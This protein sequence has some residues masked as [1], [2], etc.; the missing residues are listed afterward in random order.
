MP[1]HPNLLWTKGETYGGNR[2][3]DPLVKPTLSV[4][5]AVA[6]VAILWTWWGIQGED[7]GVI[8]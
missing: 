7:Q 4:L 3:I 6:I 5:L 8:G 2:M 1:L